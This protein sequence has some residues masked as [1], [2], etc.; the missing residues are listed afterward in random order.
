MTNTPV[1]SAE[2][3]APSSDGR[4]P[5][6]PSQMAWLT[7]E[8][9]WW[10]SEGIIEAAQADSILARYRA[11]N[12]L[13]LARLMLTLGAVF[14]GFGVIWLVAANLD[15]L[16]PLLRFIAVVLIWIGF[17]IAAEF[18]ASRREHSVGSI[19]SPVVGSFRIL[20]ALTFGAVIFQAAQSLQVPAFEPRVIAFWSLGALV[21]AYAVQSVGALTIGVI[22]GA[23]WFLTQVVW[24]QASGLGVVLALLIAGLV[25]ISI[26]AIQERWSLQMSTPWREVGAVLLLS[27]LFAA[28]IPYVDRTNFEWT[29]LLVVGV[30][31]ASVLTVAGVAL[32][33]GRGRLEPIGGLVLTGLAVLLVLWEAGQDADNVNAA[34][35]GHAAISIGAYV[36]A[37]AGV[38]VIGIFRDS[39]RLTAVATISL[40][41]FTTFQAFAVFAQ[42][43]QG[44]WLFVF[45]GVIFLV[46]GYG[47]DRVRR[48]LAATLD[49][50]NTEAGV[51]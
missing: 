3:A 39:G 46:T 12:R 2:S 38:A 6:N 40:V 48:R 33:V 24:D 34:A 41:I 49:D 26:A 31:A 45:L 5:I 36:A 10:R 51:A 42:I 7:T 27:G 16:P 15:Q 14:V 4:T 29:T 43:I 37:A 21:Y 44:A 22:A 30:V 9:G 50:D 47:F 18:L 28:A 35:W 8:L 1:V 19:P 13:S 20:A 32:G 11:T 25:A 17:L 23:G